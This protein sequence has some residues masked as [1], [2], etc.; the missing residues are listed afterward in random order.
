VV[1]LFAKFVTHRTRKGRPSPRATWLHFLCATFAAFGL[2]S[3]LIGT[4]LESDRFDI[5]GM[6]WVGTGVSFAILLG[7][8][9]FTDWRARTRA[10]GATEIETILLSEQPNTIAPDGSRIRRL[11]ELA[12]GGLSHCTLLPRQTSQAVRHRTVEEIWFVIEGEGEVWRRIGQ[13]EQTIDIHPGIGLTIPVGT[14]FQFRNSG[15]IPLRILISTMPK[16][17]GRD[18]AV[19][20]TNHWPQP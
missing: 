19:V 12:A 9:L 14:S 3:A 7:D 10:N 1:V 17:P 18:E 11:P 4:E 13:Q 6:V 5:H 8:V 2:V 15:G 16:W 20:V